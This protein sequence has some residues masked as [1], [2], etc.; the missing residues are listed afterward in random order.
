VNEI[1]WIS[2]VILLLLDLLLA[3]VRAGL[4]NARVPLLVTRRE[5][6]PHGVE[7]TITLLEKPR[8]RTS[9]RL[10]VVVTHFMLLGVVIWLFLPILNQ[11]LSLGGSLL[12]L[13]LA[14]VLLLALELVLEGIIL[15][16][17]EAWA[18]RFASLA[19]MIDFLLSP[20]SSLLMLLQG[21]PEMLRHRLSP[22][23]EDELKSWV[24]EEQP[25]GSLEQGERRMIY[26]I[27]R[28]GDTLA[29]EIMIPRIDILTLDVNTSLEEAI[30]AMNQSGH[31]RVPIYEESIDN[32]IGLLYAKDLLQVYLEGGQKVSILRSLLRPAY[33]V[34]ET[35]KVDEL[36]REMQA[37]SVHMALVVDEYGGIAGLV[38]LEDI[39][40]EIVGEIRDEYD[41]GEEQLFE[42]VADGEYIFHGRIDLDAFN[43]VMGTH[44]PKDDADTLGGFIYS[45]LGRVPVSGEKIDVDTVSLTVEQISGRRI[46][47]VRAMI[48]TD[49]TQVEEKLN[50]VETK[51]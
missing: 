35:K 12:L 45:Q 23:T 16:N 8:L 14:G 31:S 6:N 21:S 22:V 17:A 49:N 28:F 7:Q 32:I 10:G 20:V 50:G 37:R 41:Q 1:L 48:Q 47:R 39:V 18:L 24:E 4:L 44:L 11:S 42:K 36:L 2:F 46:R 19:R 27:F 51:G 33:F 5:S 38:T 29:R 15:P 9:L 25:E 3:A 40:E 43:Q 30:T 26:S 13:A 34:P